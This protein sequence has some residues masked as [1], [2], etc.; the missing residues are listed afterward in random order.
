MGDTHRYTKY[1][2]CN[3]DDQLRRGQQKQGVRPPTFNQNR[4]RR[5]DFYAV[6]IRDEV[7]AARPRREVRLALSEGK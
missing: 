7:G 6:T 2:F 5:G 3:A 1:F 4:N